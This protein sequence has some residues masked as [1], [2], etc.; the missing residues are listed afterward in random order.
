VVCIPFEVSPINPKH[1]EPALSQDAYLRLKKPKGFW[2]SSP[3]GIQ[4]LTPLI[5]LS[6]V[7]IVFRLSWTRLSAGKTVP[8]I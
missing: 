2:D 7:V 1:G 4:F 8:G 5:R 3:S 6:R